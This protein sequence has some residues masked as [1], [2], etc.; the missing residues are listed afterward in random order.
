M[1]IRD[2]QTAA[3]TP[4][5]YNHCRTSSPHGAAGRTLPHWKRLSGRHPVKYTLSSC[6]LYTSASMS[7]RSLSFSCWYFCRSKVWSRSSVPVPWTCPLYTSLISGF[8]C[9]PDRTNPSGDQPCVALHDSA[10]QVHHHLLPGGTCKRHAVSQKRC[11][12]CITSCYH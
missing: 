10:R 9:H 3:Y 11:R 4:R 5:R 6:L 12:C 1:C 8:Q 7:A 2:R